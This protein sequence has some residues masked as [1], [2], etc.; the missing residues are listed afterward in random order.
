MKSVRTYVDTS[1]FG[2]VADE[3]FKTSS[4]QFFEEVKEG[5]H[6]LVV[7]SLVVEELQHAPDA[8]RHFFGDMKNFAE[9]VEISEDCLH[10][11]RNY[12][13]AGVVNEKWRADALHVAVATVWD[14]RVLLSWN[15]RH[16]VHLQ[17]IPLYNG[18][19]MSHGYGSIAIHTPREV[20]HYED[21][22]L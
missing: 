7:S 2:G 8:V 14:C 22:N 19:N 15:F 4:A 11:M 21:K 18:V 1:V 13:E 20:L 12:I 6:Q 9:V 10:L 3:E 17:K 16:I 5:Y